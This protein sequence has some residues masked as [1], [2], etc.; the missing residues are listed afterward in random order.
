MN[1]STFK[2]IKILLVDDD[3]VSNF[4]VS[5]KLS[6]LGI[7]DINITENG[8]EA[9]DYLKSDEPHLI[10][11]DINMPIMDGHEF[12]LEFKKRKLSEQIHIFILSSSDRI[13]DKN[14]FLGFKNILDYI[15]K[16]L[17]DENILKAIN[18]L[19]LNN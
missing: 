14:K 17:E 2:K 11:L 4:I 7:L 10:F 1:T 9:I 15:E 12:I 6:K 13:C 19:N 8:S 3:P 16:P 5:R 18:T